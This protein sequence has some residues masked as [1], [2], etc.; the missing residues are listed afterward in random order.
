MAR[1]AGT[2]AE[3]TGVG[4]GVQQAPG[5]AGFEYLAG[6]ASLLLAVVRE[7]VRPPF[8]WRR[9]FVEQC[10]LILHRCIVPLA[11]TTFAAGVGTEGFDGGGIARQIG[12]LDRFGTGYATAGLREFSPFL[13]GLVVAGVIGTAVCAD[14]GARKVRDELDATAVL[15]VNPISI[16]VAPRFLAFVVM[17]PLMAFFAFVTNI[18]GGIV[19][20]AVYYD[21]PLAVFLGSFPIQLNAVDI[22]I[23]T[24]LKCAVYGVVI[25]LVFSYEGLNAKGGAEGVGRAVNRGVVIVFVSIF[26]LNF[27]LNSIVLASF[28]ELQQAK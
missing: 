8:R 16:L 14:L 6:L 18:A 13:T 20:F 7:L 4:R 24:I 2:T 15:G 9:D 26:V 22:Y 1:A 21:V 25:A 27:A 28:P 23:G 11:I 12:V 19:V 3:A 10:V 5:Y 17:T